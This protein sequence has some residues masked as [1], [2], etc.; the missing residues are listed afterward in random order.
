LILD[1][2]RTRGRTHS[3]GPDRAQRADLHLPLGPGPH[4]TM[5]LIHGGS[6]QEHYGRFVMRALARDLCKRGWA[7]WNIEYR[8]LGAG[9]GWPQ[10]FT[11]VAAA[12][13]HLREVDAPLDLDRVSVLGHSA[14]GHLALWAA[15]R[16][17]LPPGVPGAPDG[18]LPVSF[19]RAISLAGVCD[20]AGGYRDWH[21][22]AVKELM[23]G[24]PE[25]LPE[26]YAVADPLMQVPLEMPVLLVHGVLDAT[27]SI[28]LSR[29]YARAT[30]AAGG[31]V[32]LVEIAG[33]AVPHKEH[34]DPHRPSWTAVT[35]WLEQPVDDQQA[36][37]AS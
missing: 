35:R 4:P 24:S 11:D 10:T 19:Q 33:N 30:R 13:D 17:K 29:R 27:V 21:G 26:R 3:Y 16:A 36:L 9:G 6:W 8:R 31:E 37:A 15:G 5:V 1:L 7:V 23:G 32:E 34:V 20:L 14:G 12:I 18:D 25:E 28:E 22:G 2:L